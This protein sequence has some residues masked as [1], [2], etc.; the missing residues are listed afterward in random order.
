MAWPEAEGEEMTHDELLL[1]NLRGS[2]STALHDAGATAGEIEE[3][4]DDVLDALA[5]DLDESMAAAAER[6]L[7]RHREGRSAAA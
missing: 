3:L 6:L 7:R 5:C 4:I 1:R 2:A